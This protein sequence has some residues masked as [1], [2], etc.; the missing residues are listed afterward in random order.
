MA[1]MEFKA[2][3]VSDYTPWTLSYLE[4]AKGLEKSN[5][6]H[7]TTNSTS[8]N[9]DKIKDDKKVEVALA[10]SHVGTNGGGYSFGNDSSKTSSTS[11]TSSS[12]ES[13]FIFGKSFAAM[14]PTPS[15]SKLP[16]IDSS[17][18]Q[19]TPAPADSATDAQSTSATVDPAA[20]EFIFAEIWSSTGAEL[21]GDDSFVQ[22]KSDQNCMT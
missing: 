2:N 15:K 20:V 21:I 5:N 12:V 3:S 18:T 22:M 10:P 17:D 16:T 13:G 8:S 11:T 4:K 19:S 14:T 9:V 1:Q 6:K 7:S